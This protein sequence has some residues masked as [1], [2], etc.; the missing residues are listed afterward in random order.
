MVKSCDAWHRPCGARMRAAG[1]PLIST[2][3]QKRPV[4]GTNVHRGT[5]RAASS[6]RRR[7]P[8]LIRP[9]PRRSPERRPQR[10]RV[11]SLDRS[12]ASPR[13]APGWAHPAVP[14]RCLYK[15]PASAEPHPADCWRDRPMNFACAR[16]HEPDRANNTRPVTV[17]PGAFLWLSR[18]PSKLSARAVAAPSAPPCIVLRRTP[19]TLNGADRKSVV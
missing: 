13:C 6:L 17:V 19:R 7:R 12:G 3:P 11:D 2:I 1:I 18:C 15:G 10:R 4:D 14:H 16:T 5:F 9:A 8:R